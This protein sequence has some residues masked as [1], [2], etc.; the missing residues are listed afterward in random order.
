[1]LPDYP[2]VKRKLA[3]KMQDQLKQEFAQRLGFLNG[4]DRSIVFEGSRSKIV[5]EDGSVQ[6]SDFQE[7]STALS[8]STKE[9]ESLTPEQMRVKIENA[10]D[11]LAQKQSSLA[12]ETIR[13]E[14]EKVGNSFDAKGQPFTA[15]LFLD[16]LENIEMDFD[17]VSNKPRLPT[18]VANPV[19]IPRMQQELKRLDDDP[20][21]RRRFKE[22]IDRKRSDWVAR[23]SSRKLVR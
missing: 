13:K 7:I 15:E 2:T 18:L 3:T 5:R 9:L 6:E 12:F 22:I 20:E 4:I 19:N 21:C 1:M 8:I 10:A 23:E 16:G 17:P 14:V 11:E